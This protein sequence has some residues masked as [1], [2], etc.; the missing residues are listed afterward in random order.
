MRR[1]KSIDI[2]NMIVISEG[3]LD[4]FRVKKGEFEKRIKEG[5]PSDQIVIVHFH[6]YCDPHNPNH[7]IL[8]G[9]PVYTKRAQNPPEEPI[10]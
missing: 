10:S 1:Q 9:E 5:C 2:A 6:E 3:P 7:Y 8:Y 4:S